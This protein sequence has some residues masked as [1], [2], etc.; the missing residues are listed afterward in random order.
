MDVQQL[1][2]VAG[3]Q[4]FEHKISLIHLATCWKYSEIHRDYSS[5]TIAQVYRRTLDRFPTF[6]LP[7]PITQ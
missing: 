2:A 3:N 1:P 6:L 4:G 7:S 5:Q